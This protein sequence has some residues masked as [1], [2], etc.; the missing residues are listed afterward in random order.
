MVDKRAR[1]ARAAPVHA[2]FG[3]ARYED[4]LCILAA[5]LHGDVGLR[6][7]R[8]DRA[9]SRLHFLHEFDFTALRDAQPRRTRNT[10]AECIAVRTELFQLAEHALLHA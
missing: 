8:F 10:R 1:T 6:I 5:Q 9:V 3:S 2:L 4:N 7:K